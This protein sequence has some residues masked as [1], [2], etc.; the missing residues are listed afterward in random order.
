MDANKF[1]KL[2]YTVQLSLI[3]AM[4]IRN[5]ME[6]F[7][8]E[9]LSDEQ[10]KKLNP[11]I[12]Q[13]VY[14]ILRYLTLAANEKMSSKKNAAQALITFQMQLIPDYGNFQ[15]KRSLKRT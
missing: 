9:H 5:E 13:A 11:I 2:D 8:S 12:R 4:Y 7:H 15:A 14:N 6:R 1:K 10:M 3:I